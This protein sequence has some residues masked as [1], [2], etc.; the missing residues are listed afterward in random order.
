[1]YV[2]SV[3]FVIFLVTR[4]MTGTALARARP[5][6]AHAHTV[7]T[8]AAPSVDDSLR[9]NAHV[10][11]YIAY[12][13]MFATVV[14]GVLT[15]A[16]T[17]RRSVRRQTLYDIHMLLSIMAITATG[18]HALT[19]ML[20]QVDP[21]TV[22][23]E[24]VPFA[25]PVHITLGVIA[26][27]LMVVAA[28]SVSIQQ[29]LSY[30][31]WHRVHRIAYPAYVLVIVHVLLSAHHR[32]DGVVITALATTAGVVVVVALVGALPTIRANAEE[33]T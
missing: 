17:I 28:V 14:L 4:G 21:F 23:E 6:V 31:R 1:L 19:H 22:A 26:F 20:K 30:H 8:T 33:L 16:G 25:T 18:L 2:V 5:D 7:R 3:I 10:A 11:G 12:A 15:S 24:V 32:S 13:L 9:R 29:Q 27:E